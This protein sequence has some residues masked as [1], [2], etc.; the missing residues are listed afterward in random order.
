MLLQP[1]LKNAKERPQA[2]AII[3]DRG[4]M[5]WA[6]LLKK[7]RRLAKLL[8]SRTRNEKVAIL[9]PSGGGFVTSFYAIM[10]AG[11]VAV[12]INFL[13]GERET[14][15]VLKD[16][17]VDL[18]LTVG[19]MLDKLEAGHAIKK[20]AS[21]GNVQVIDLLALK[22]NLK[23]LLAQL[24]PLPRTERD[25]DQLAALLYTS[26]TS[27]VPKGVELTQG[28]L[29]SDV[30][31]CI[32]HA[33]LDEVGSSHVFL[34][35]VPLFHSTGLLATMLAPITLGATTVYIARFS[36]HGTIKAIRDHGVS[37]MAAVPS[38]YNAISRVKDAGPADFAKMYAPI[39]GGEPLPA[40]VREMFKRRFDADLM[41]GY[42]LTETCGP[43]CV[44]MPHAHRPGSVG[45]AL[46][47]VE[48]SITDDAGNSLKTN[49]T[50]EI[51]IR[52]PM[53]FRGYHGLPE[54]TA[55][56]TSPTGFFKSGDLGHIDDD[57]YLFITGRKKD[58]LIVSGENVYPREIEEAICTL[59]AASEAAVVGRPDESRGEVPVAFVIA[60]EGME[61]GEA[62]VK[63][64]LREMGL[65]P[66]KIPKEVRIVE[67]LPRSPTGKV[68]K[69][70][71]VEQLM[72]TPANKAA[73]A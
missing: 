48:L 58:M 21:A 65:P 61:V 57:G 35:V 53:V 27:G 10:L 23:A 13:L 8:R 39:S 28:N 20:A 37:V 50:G 38:M 47:G 18:V 59:E 24:R 15:H 30:M 29:H 11:K 55:S 14:A 25:T 63:A 9:L 43:I 42:G 72:T 2:T 52:G 19:L 56:V 1:V 4:S 32:K 31:A 73:V 68:L 71:L 60:V 3:D 6:D 34:G 51:W 67:E 66:F 36:P 45:Q 41:E 64:H 70:Q 16:S 49:D 26:G 69:R 62:A 12:P 17:G 7:A 44:N 54:Q 46:E 5:T 33:R 22:P 40:G